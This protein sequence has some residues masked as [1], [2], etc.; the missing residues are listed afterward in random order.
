MPPK[1]KR[2]KTFDELV[3]SCKQHIPY[4]NLNNRGRI[5]KGWSPDHLIIVSIDPGRANLGVMVRVRYR[6][7]KQIIALDRLYSKEDDYLYGNI[8]RHLNNYKQYLESAHYIFIERQ[9]KINY[10]ATRIMQHI[11]SYL[12]CLLLN[13]S[14]QPYIYEIP[15]ELKSYRIARLLYDADVLPKMDKPTLKKKS[16]EAADKSLSIEQDQFG[17]QEL[18]KDSK[19]DDRADTLM[20]EESA[21]IVLGLDQWFAA[22]PTYVQ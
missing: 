7:R 21:Y 15:A 8:V 22:V 6:N 14:I 3:K 2:A 5:D 4:D 11:I 19:K 12:C 20:M 10:K 16:V 1:K 17:L 18:N 13:S 9:L